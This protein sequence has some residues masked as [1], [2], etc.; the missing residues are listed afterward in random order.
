[1]DINVYSPVREENSTKSMNLLT[2][3][4]L[5]WTEYRPGKTLGPV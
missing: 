5:H 2:C 3:R 1:M 4:E